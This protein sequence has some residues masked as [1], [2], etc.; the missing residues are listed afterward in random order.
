[1]TRFKIGDGAVS[2]EILLYLVLCS[3]NM[4]CLHYLWVKVTERSENG[5]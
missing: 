4:F 1:M 3:G 2:F 5:N